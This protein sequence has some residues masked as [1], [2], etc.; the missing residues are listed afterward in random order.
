[1]SSFGQK[2]VKTRKSHVCVPLSIGFFSP[3][4]IVLL[5]I[6]TFA[7]NTYSYIQICSGR[8]R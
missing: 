6:A 1:M 3:P 8:P 7:T 5:G 4:T 2:P